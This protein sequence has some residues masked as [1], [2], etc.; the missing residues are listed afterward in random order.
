MSNGV[1]G[2]H[3]PGPLRIVAG[4]CIWVFAIVIMVLGIGLQAFPVTSAIGK[5]VSKPVMGLSY[6]GGAYMGSGLVDTGVLIGQGFSF[7]FKKGSKTF[8]E[9]ITR[10]KNDD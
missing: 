5:A 7:L 8:E 4:F 6:T 2:D 1:D 9:R 3:I 10:S